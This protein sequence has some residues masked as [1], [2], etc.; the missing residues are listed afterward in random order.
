MMR[1]TVVMI[2]AATLL[3][4]CAMGGGAS[5]PVRVLSAEGSLLHEQQDAEQNQQLR[6][7]WLQREVVVLKMRPDFAYRV[8]LDASSTQHWL[9]AKEGYAVM[10]S[11]PYGDIYRMTARSR[12]N[13]LLQ[14]A[15]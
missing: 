9:Y 4:S 3:S 11:A 5:I 10:A 2:A 13:Q 14:I 8:E 7:L 12:I 6:Q 15:Q 1:F